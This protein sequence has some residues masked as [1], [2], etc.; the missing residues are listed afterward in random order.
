M[1][2]AHVLIRVTLD[3]TLT[4]HWNN[5]QIAAASINVV[6]KSVGFLGL[7][8]VLKLNPNNDTL[9]Q[10]VSPQSSQYRIF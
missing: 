9:L 6:I 5:I 10:M 8:K 2:V 3:R 7:K 4:G 1:N